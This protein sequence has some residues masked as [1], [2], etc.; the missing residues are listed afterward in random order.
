MLACCWLGALAVACLELS[1]AEEG[2]ADS[3]AG[4]GGDSGGWPTGGGAGAS[5]NAGSSSGGSAGTSAGGSDAGGASGFQ[6]RG[7]RFD[8]S[9]DWLELTTGFLNTFDTTT[10]SGSLWIKRAGLGTTQC[11]GP[12]AAGSGSPNQLELTSAN[13]FRVVWRQ[14]GG[15]I[16]CDFHSSPIVDTTQWHH[17]LFSVDTSA[18]KAQLWVDGFSD[19]SVSQLFS[20]KLDNTGS[21]W[22]LFADNGGANKFDGEVAEVWIAMGQFVDFSTPENRAKF[23]SASGKPVDLASNGA[24]PTGTAPTIY[25]SLRTGDAPSAFSANRGTGGGF[26]IHGGLDASLTSP[27]D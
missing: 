5:G 17:V 25:L 26:V 21:Q 4:T 9:A 2:R 18:S 24:A 20:V 7:V 8:G 22:G 13:T 11:I 3:G 19:I 14:A 16:A 15:G 6:V 10:A 12:E 1:P 23:R 27:S